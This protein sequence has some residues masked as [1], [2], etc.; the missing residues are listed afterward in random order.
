MKNVPSYP[1]SPSFLPS[2]PGYDS[3]S[4]ACLFC[5][6]VFYDCT[7]LNVLMIRTECVNVNVNDLVCVSLYR[8]N[9]LG[10]LMISWGFVNGNGVSVSGVGVVSETRS[11]TDVYDLCVYLRPCSRLG[12]EIVVG[13]SSLRGLFHPYLFEKTYMGTDSSWRCQNS[14]LSWPCRGAVNGKQNERQN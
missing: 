11:E 8:G 4:Y 6:Y 13:I 2:S 3:V 7:S 10:I 14:C 12:P 1:F 9:C 5:A